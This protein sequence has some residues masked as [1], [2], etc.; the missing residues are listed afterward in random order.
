[1]KLDHTLDQL[2]RHL[3]ERGLRPEDFKNRHYNEKLSDLVRN[4]GNMDK[5]SVQRDHIIQLSDPIY[6]TNLRPAHIFD[7]RAHFYAPEKPFLFRRFNTFWFNITVI[8][9]FTVL[10]YVTLYFEVLRK[11]LRVLRRN[12][13][14]SGVR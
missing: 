9:G 10:L 11:S 7:Y 2:N 3:M 1:M 13:N 14:S 4:T 12:K 5:I 6:N 8:W